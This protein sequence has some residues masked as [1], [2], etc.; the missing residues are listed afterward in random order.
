QQLGRRVDGFR[1]P[2]LDR[3]PDL[4][5]AV[6]RVGFRYDSSYPDVDRENMTHFGAGVRL[7]VPFRPPLEDGD[8]V[9]PS[10]CLELPV[11]APDCI[12]PLFEGD[13]V[14]TLRRA[15]RD[16][17]EFI[18]ATGG[19]YVGIVHAGVFGT[20]DAL[21]RA[22]H[23]AFVREQLLHSDVWVAPAS[24]IA[25]WWCDRERLTLTVGDDCVRVMNQG[26]R[27]VDGIRVLVDLG[28]HEQAHD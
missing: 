9:R 1:S 6:E 19:L 11:S 15:V 18:R 26:N 10:A 20:R 22:T 12:Q 2:R 25:E 28:G 16:K 5:W 7:N 24:E 14:C 21:R 23:L 8:R 4:L 27:P 3:S 13:D 17:V